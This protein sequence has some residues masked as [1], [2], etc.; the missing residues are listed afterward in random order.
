[1]IVEQ[2][3]RILREIH[4][5]GTPVLLV[6]QSTETALALAQRVYVMSKGQI[7][8]SGSLRD[9]QDN[10]SVRRQFLEV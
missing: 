8:F 4:R 7:V 5:S 9:L 3:E 10:E 1:M 6:E 2:V